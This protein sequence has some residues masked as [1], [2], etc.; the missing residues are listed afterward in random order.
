[1]KDI[2]LLFM[3]LAMGTRSFSSLTQHEWQD[4]FV[5]TI[6]GYTVLQC[7]R[8][9]MPV[10]VSCRADRWPLSR[11]TSYYMGRFYGLIEDANDVA[12]LSEHFADR[13][14]AKV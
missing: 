13:G 6:P 9:K 10:I 8:W 12:G 1:M 7:L 5:Y 11:V 14:K 4:K 3:N 2:K